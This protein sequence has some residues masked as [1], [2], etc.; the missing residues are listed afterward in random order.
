MRLKRVKAE[1]VDVRRRMVW[2]VAYLHSYGESDSAGG[3]IWC[4]F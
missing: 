2:L 1:I 3:G 4:T